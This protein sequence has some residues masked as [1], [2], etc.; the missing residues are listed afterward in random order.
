MTRA[1]QIAILIWK[2]EGSQLTQHKFSERCHC[3][4]NI[5]IL[6]WATLSLTVGMTSFGFPTK[7][8]IRSQHFI[9]SK[10]SQEFARLRYFR[11]NHANFSL[12]WL[13]MDIGK[14]YMYVM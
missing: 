5:W 10:H 14:E 9:P 3:I 8:T 11:L 13:I 6:T 7:T 1:I 12:A 4:S 2:A